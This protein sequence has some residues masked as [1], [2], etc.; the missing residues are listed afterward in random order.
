M[1]KK[2][3]ALEVNKKNRKFLYESDNKLVFKL[4]ESP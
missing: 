1:T 2:Y 4:I 3:I